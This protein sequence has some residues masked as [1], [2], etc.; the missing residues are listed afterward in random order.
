MKRLGILFIL[1][2]KT[3]CLS[4]QLSRGPYLQVVTPTSI[5]IRWRT[6]F[7]EDSKVS[8][9]TSVDKLTSIAN[10]LA[11]PSIEHEVQLKDLLPNTKYYYAIG[12]SFR[13]L[14][15]NANNY[16]MTAPVVGS[17]QKVR[18]LALGDCG[19]R[20][21]NQILVR[22]Q[23]LKYAQDKPIQLTLLLGDNA[24]IYGTD[25]DYKTGFFESY[26][27]NL[28]KNTVLFP[29]M[30]NHD[31]G[32]RQDLAISKQVAYFDIFTLP[33][34]GEAGGVP[35][36][37]EAY[38]SY[39]YANIH[40]IALDSYGIEEGDKKFYDTLSPQIVWLKKDLA[41]NKQRWTIAYW[42]HPPYTKGSYDSDIVPELYLSR[43]N[44]LR[45]LERNGVD[46]VL[47]GHSHVYERSAL[48]R[49]HYGNSDSFKA[50]LHS[51]GKSNGRYDNSAN[52]CP[53]VKNER[54]TVYVVAGTGAIVIPNTKQ[55]SFPHKAMVY[56]NAE[57]SGAVMVEVEDNRL[58]LKWICEDGIIRDQF[59]LMKQVNK[60]TEISAVSGQ[61]LKLNASWS[62]DYVW[63]N[64]EKIQNINLT[65][66][67]NSAKYFVTDKQKCLVDSFLVTI[68][69]KANLPEIQATV[70]PNPANDRLD[71]TYEIPESGRY[72]VEL[73]DGNGNILS[74]IKEEFLEKGV[75]QKNIPLPENLPNDKTFFVKVLSEIYQTT[76]KVVI[77]K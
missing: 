33:Q 51:I 67:T 54:G 14:Q 61:N 20:T 16:F 48:L 34:K 4:A 17:T 56:S 77:I 39:N 21:D 64:G 8:F 53:L 50:K 38:Y 55:E 45:I 7:V 68:M 65:N 36:A 10:P 12:S 11:V 70:F 74:Q 3:F 6:D 62:G 43:Q 5:T 59:T 30:G 25:D 31:Y 32:N 58:D 22:D 28:L 40:F 63:N 47:C 29:A 15:G 18:F 13:T 72:S 66:L 24:Y 76:K 9:G 37:S 42:H 44:L 73:F 41:A 60:Y 19:F 27:G 75:Y 52:S 2:F 49:S 69:P 71:V 1:F 26:Q 46:L 35:S 57:N 23:F